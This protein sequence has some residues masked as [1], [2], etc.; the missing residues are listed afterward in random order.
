MDKSNDAAAMQH[1]E[2]G[3]SGHSGKQ[4]NFNPHKD[5]Q[6]FKDDVNMGLF[7]HYGICTVNSAIDLSWGMMANKPW[8]NKIGCEYRISPR[9]YWALAEDFNPC[10]FETEIDKVLKKAKEAGFAYAVFTTRHHDGYAM[11]PSEYGDFNI[12]NYHKDMDLVRMYVDACRKNDI[13]VGLYFSPPD[14]YWFKDYRS[15]NYGSDIFP[16]RPHYDID[17]NTIDKVNEP[18]EEFMDKYREYVGNQVRELLTNY[19]KI[20]VLWFD[21]SCSEPNKA[22]S[23]DEIYKLQPGIVVNDRMHQ[24]GDFTTSEVTMPEEKPSNVW[25]HCDILADCPWWAYMAQA[26]RLHTVDW[27]Y[28]R[29]LHCKEWGGNFLINIGP[30]CDGTIPETVYECL[31]A[32]IEK[33]KREN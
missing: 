2:I 6:W 10:R 28:N 14:W 24:D 27:L 20:D 16:D 29:Y 21:G 25:E 13:K 30:K 18:T 1:I 26:Y 31:D 8:E 33:C 7:I 12:G 3:V 32:F 5:A 19:G 17:H 4:Y 9:N 11:W 15:F 22:I 23:L